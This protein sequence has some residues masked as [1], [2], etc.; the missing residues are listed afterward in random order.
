MIVYN[1][2]VQPLLAFS[3]QQALKEAEHVVLK[4]VRQRRPDESRQRRAQAQELVRKKLDALRKVHLVDVLRH[5]QLRLRARH[6]Q[7]VALRREARHQLADRVVRA[8][9]V[10][11]HVLDKSRILALTNQK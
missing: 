2:H 7:Y 9:A 6:Q 11:L 3:V 8:E 4:L 5:D 10:A 1:E